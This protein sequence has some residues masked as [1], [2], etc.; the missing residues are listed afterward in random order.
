M[1]FTGN[2]SNWQIGSIAIGLLFCTYV[3]RLETF[4]RSLMN[5]HIPALNNILYIF[6]LCFF[7]FFFYRY[8]IV[9]VVFLIYA[10]LHTTCVF[11]LILSLYIFVLLT[12]VTIVMHQ[13]TN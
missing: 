10:S 1:L 5:S 13:N 12:I 11:C 8:F 3:L 4:A 2:R 9:S 6:L 7:F